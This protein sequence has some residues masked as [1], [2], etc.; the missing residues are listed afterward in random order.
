M[1]SWRLRKPLHAVQYQHGDNEHAVF[2]IVNARFFWPA[3]VLSSPLVFLGLMQRAQWV[4]AVRR[5]KVAGYTCRPAIAEDVAPATL[6]FLNGPA[7]PEVI[8]GA[9]TDPAYRD[10]A[11]PP[12]LFRIQQNGV[13]FGHVFLAGVLFSILLGC[14]VVFMTLRRG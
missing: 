9:I 13:K 3:V 4:S 7:L 10:S 11:R 6:T 5:G 2:A 8:E 12:I 1:S 14:A